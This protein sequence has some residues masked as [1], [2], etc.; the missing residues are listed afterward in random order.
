MK[1]ILLVKLDGIGDYLFLRLFW[2]QLAALAKRRDIALDLL[3]SSV[4]YPFA[5]RYDSAYF[6]HILMPVHNEHRYLKWFFHFLRN[7]IDKRCKDWE[8]CKSQ[9]WDASFLVQVARFGYMDFVM[10]GLHCTCK[11]AVT[12]DD[13]YISRVERCQN[14]QEVYSRLLPI[15]KNEFILENYRQLL[16]SMFEHP[17][18]LPSLFLPFK[19]EEIQPQIRHDYG[20]KEGEPYTVFVPSTSLKM[21]DW[22]LAHFVQLAKRLAG[23]SC[24]KILILGRGTPEQAQAFNAL[25]SCGP[26]IN[27]FNKTS[28][29]QACKWAAGA[30]RAVCVDTALMHCALW[31]GADCICISNGSSHKLFLEYPPELGVKQTICYS[32]EWAPGHELLSVQSLSSL[33][34]SAVWQCVCQ[35]G[36]VESV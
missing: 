13:T 25:K 22:P 3:C 30:S 28:L 16:S 11:I 10:R 33:S 35:R 20:L 31:G 9:H 8:W 15:H 4:C 23:S 21:R 7:K 29:E 32:P 2:P 5:A 6:R 1:E 12:G 17:F 14:N 26:V 24:Q 18:T 36:W 19:K 34:V 27:L